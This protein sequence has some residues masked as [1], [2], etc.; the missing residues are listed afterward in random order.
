M[1]D[2]TTAHSLADRLLRPCFHPQRLPEKL[3]FWSEP[4][5]LVRVSRVRHSNFST[6]DKTG[7]SKALGAD[8]DARLTARVSELRDMFH[9]SACRA[10]CDVSRSI[11]RLLTGFREALSCCDAWSG[12]FGVGLGGQVRVSQSS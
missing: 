2:W 4:S 11:A 5:Y 3:V 7:C 6:A 12:G 10:Y 1:A 9:A 8:R